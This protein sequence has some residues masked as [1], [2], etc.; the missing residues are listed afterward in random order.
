M[1]E[2]PLP[3]AGGYTATLARHTA[4]A[5]LPGC[6]QR[7]AQPPRGPDHDTASTLQTGRHEHSVSS[8]S[9]QHHNPEPLRYQHVRHHL[10]ARRLLPQTRGRP[11]WRDSHELSHRNGNQASHDLSPCAR[12]PPNCSVGKS[13]GL[14]RRR[15]RTGMFVL[16]PPDAD[17]LSGR[18]LSC[19]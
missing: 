1:K 16:C 2:T 8:Q 18:M 15:G 12:D 10:P 14:T 11:N 13:H 6:G 5:H 3:G 19:L 4:T 17:R 7:A 9:G